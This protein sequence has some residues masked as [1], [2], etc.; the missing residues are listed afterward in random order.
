MLPANLVTMPIR[1]VQAV[2]KSVRV[3]FIARRHLRHRWNVRP[4][5]IRSMAPPSVRAVAKVTTPVLV[6][7][8]IVLFALLG[9]IVPF[10]AQNLFYVQREARQRL[11]QLSA[12]YAHQATILIRPKAQMAVCHAQPDT[13]APTLLLTLEY[14]QKAPSPK[15]HPLG[16]S[17]VLA[18]SMPM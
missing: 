9:L 11:E 14:V 15:K 6:L 7:Q 18:V 10:L 4:G 8:K 5:H 16:V 12:S 3:D 1:M 13:L 2:V 17:L